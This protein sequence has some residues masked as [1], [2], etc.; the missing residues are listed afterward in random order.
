MLYFTS[1]DDIKTLKLHHKSK[2]RIDCLKQ[3]TQIR[4]MNETA[5]QIYGYFDVNATLQKVGLFRYFDQTLFVANLIFKCTSFV[6]YRLTTV[7][8]GVHRVHTQEGQRARSYS[9]Q[10]IN[11]K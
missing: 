9:S 10:A 5:M 11:D 3:I 2:Y 7:T 8:P 1:S 4:V 6:I